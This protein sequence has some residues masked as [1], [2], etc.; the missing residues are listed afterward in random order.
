MLFTISCLLRAA[1]TRC[2]KPISTIGTIE[3]LATVIV[4]RQEMLLLNA[5]HLTASKLSWPPW[6]FETIPRAGPS[7]NSPVHGSLP[8]SETNDQKPRPAG[9]QPTHRWQ[10]MN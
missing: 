6:S 8:P 7:R 3:P 2:W 10:R 4:P 5:R 9:P 1:H